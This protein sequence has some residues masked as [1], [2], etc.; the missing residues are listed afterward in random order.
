MMI[1]EN[2]K[3]QVFYALRHFP[4]LATS[5]KAAQR[6]EETQ[7]HDRKMKI[8][9]AIPICDPDPASYSSQK[10]KN[11]TYLNDVERQTLNKTWGSVREERKL[12]S[13][14]RRNIS[15]AHKMKGAVVGADCV[16]IN[17]LHAAFWKLRSS[18]FPGIQ[19]QDDSFIL[20]ARG[21]M[22]VLGRD[23]NSFVDEDCF[24][25]RIAIVLGVFFTPEESQA[26]HSLLFDTDNNR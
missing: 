9:R 6:M 14:K 12:N 19:Q 25:E 23:C 8:K 7:V 4:E 10:M 15:T 21:L 24:R 13:A 20:D 2:N 11:F 26:F 3:H 16:P 17:P 18:G 1:P 5:F 22:A